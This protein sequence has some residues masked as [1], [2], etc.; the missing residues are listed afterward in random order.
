MSKIRQE[1]M[2]I[3]I[4]R[5]LSGIIQQGLKDPRID[6][7]QI[8]ITRIDLSRDYS[9]ARVNLSILGDAEWQGQQFKALQAAAG[10]IR[11]ALAAELELRHA[12]ELEFRL[13]KSIEHGIYISSL[14]DRIKQQ[15]GSNTEGE[16]P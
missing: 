12:P 10:H 1:R 7:S 3:Q 8:S 16:T 11:S 13:D 4:Q 15:E 14:L 9:H 2:S 6:G 5:I